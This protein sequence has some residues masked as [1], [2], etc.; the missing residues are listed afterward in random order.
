VQRFYK[1]YL[2]LMWVRNWRLRFDKQSDYVLAQF[3]ILGEDF[4]GVIVQVY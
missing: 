4:G 3:G 2:G 1:V